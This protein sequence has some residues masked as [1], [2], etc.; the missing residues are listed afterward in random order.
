MRNAPR[1]II[2][3]IGG[4]SG[5][6]YGLRALAMLKAAG[7]ETHLVMTLDAQAAIARETPH[8]ASD[9]HA[10]AAAVYR[11]DDIAAPIS[12]GSFMTAGM[13]VAPCSAGSLSMIATGVTS[14]LLSRAADVVLKERRRLVLM[15][16]ETPLHLGHLRAMTRV[17][18]MG[19]IAMPPVPDLHPAPCSVGDVIDRSLSHA[20]GH[21]TVWVGA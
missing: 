2:L 3:G 14:D 10:L 11:P 16:C 5:G 6:L 18:E 13:L 4:T 21:F 9:I 17:T 12:S 8:A 20:L 15:V 1:R 19:A 7:L